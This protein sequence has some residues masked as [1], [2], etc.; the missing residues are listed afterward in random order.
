MGSLHSLPGRVSCQAIT[1]HPGCP[2]S[3][4]GGGSY[5]RGRGQAGEHKFQR[6]HPQD[7]KA[8]HQNKCISGLQ[9]SIWKEAPYPWGEGEVSGFHVQS[10]LGIVH[11]YHLSLL[12]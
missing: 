5:P 1:G 12:L 10:L 3:L 9:M 4:E 11:F 2:T 8:A 6:D 7:W